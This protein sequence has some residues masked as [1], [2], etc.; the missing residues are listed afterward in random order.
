MRSSLSDKSFFGP[1][2][3]QLEL[4]V[5][6]CVTYPISFAASFMNRFT[7]HTDQIYYKISAVPHRNATVKLSFNN[8]LTTGSI[9]ARRHSGFRRPH[10]RNPIQQFRRINVSDTAEQL[11]RPPESRNEI[12]HIRLHHPKWPHEKTQNASVS[13]NVHDRN[14]T[15]F[16]PGTAIGKF[17]KRAHKTI[18]TPTIDFNHTDGFRKHLF[19]LGQFQW[20]S[21]IATFNVIRSTIC[22]ESVP[23]IAQSLHRRESHRSHCCGRNRCHRRSDH[24]NTGRCTI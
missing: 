5:R 6:D 18:A 20:H 12:G 3:S 16:R 10:R 19:R 14:R 24:R 2:T 17:R 15:T 21:L 22:P 7:A 13:A 23:R 8:S 1:V 9:H 4:H 11:H